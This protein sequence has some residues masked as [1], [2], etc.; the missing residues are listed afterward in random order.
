MLLSRMEKRKRRNKAIFVFAVFLYTLSEVV[1]CGHVCLILCF[2]FL[3][4]ML[5]MGEEKRVK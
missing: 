3:F 5:V 2:Y 4:S 1:L